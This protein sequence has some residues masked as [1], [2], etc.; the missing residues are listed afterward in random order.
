MKDEIKHYF[1]NDGDAQAC[2]YT[3]NP[4]TAKTDD[5]PVGTSE[6]EEL[7]D[8]QF[9]KGAR[10]KFKDFKLASFRLNVSSSYSTLAKNAITQLLV[11][12]TTSECEQGF[13]NFLVIKSKA[14][15]HLENPGHDFR[16]SMSKISPRLAKLVEEKQA[17]P[18]H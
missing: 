3:R 1:F 7:I 8:L 17:Q 18:L 9:D 11:F 14:R 16:C 4:F 10:E 15:N 6:Q 2:T 12:S 13:S 5:L